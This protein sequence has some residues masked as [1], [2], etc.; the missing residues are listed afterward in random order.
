MNQHLLQNL[1]LLLVYCFSFAG[2]SSLQAQEQSF[3]YQGIEIEFEAEH[4]SKNKKANH[5]EEGDAVTLKFS[6]KDTLSKQGLSGVFPAA[7]MSQDYLIENRSCKRKI[8]TFL[9]SSILDQPELDLNVYYVLTMNEDASINVVDPLFGYG[10]SKLLNRIVLNSPGMD[11]ALTDNQNYLFVS[12]PKAKQVAVIKTTTWEVVK[13]LDIPGIP[14]HTEFQADEAYLWV[15][16]VSEEEENEEKTGVVAINVQNQNI[17]KVIPTGNGWHEI[18]ISDDNQFV[19]ITNAKSNNVS[20]IDIHSLA[21][22]NQ[23]AVADNPTTI[24]WSNLAQAAYVGHKSLGEI[25]VI[26]GEKQAIST[27]INVGKGLEQVTFAPGH[28]YGF[29]VNPAKDEVSIFDASSNR[30]VQVADVDSQPDQVNFSDG[31]AYIRHRNSENILMIALPTIGQMGAPVQVVDFPGGQ[32]PAGKTNYPSVASGIVQA[33]G[34]SAVLVANPWDQTVY[35]YMEGSAAPMGSFSNYSR[36]PRAVMVVDRSLQEKEKGVY[37][38]SVQL[39]KPGVYDVAFFM[40]TPRIVHCFQLKIAPNPAL[41][42]KE[43]F[44][45]MGT[46]KI[47]FLPQEEQATNLNSTVKFQ[48]KDR[49]TGE[50]LGGLE[51]VKVM[52]MTPS[53]TW[54]SR[55]WAKDL[56]HSGT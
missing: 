32:N 35:F 52:V 48:V 37:Q 6:I 2:I 23:I 28:R 49:K 4:L 9:S 45:Q 34:E 8:E 21:V 20:A 43:A 53:A 39:P 24:T 18:T 3:I 47:D 29:V 38:T 12:M 16:Y 10:G 27:T 30:I 7:W 1:K 31:I 22:K 11:W 15:T 14:V 26:D 5:F 46:L 54:H 41:Q 17:E 40:N 56:N 44:E 19:Y 13:N 25:T 33:V 51:D 55:D 42:R 50:L 36:E